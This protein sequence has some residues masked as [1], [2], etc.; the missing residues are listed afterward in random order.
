LGGGK[1]P[2]VAIYGRRRPLHSS[3][4]RS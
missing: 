4:R 2:D 1:W 3:F